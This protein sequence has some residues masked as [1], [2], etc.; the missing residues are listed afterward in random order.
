MDAA[1][2]I[3]SGLLAISLAA[4]SAAGSAGSP[5]KTKPQV[6]LLVLDELPIASLMKPDGNIDA[7]LFPNFARLQSDAT[8]FRNATSPGTFTHDVIPSILTGSRPSERLQEASFLPNNLFTLLSPTHRIYT[9]QPFPR[10]CPATM[11]RDMPRASK[12]DPL[13]RL[14]PAFSAGARGEKFMSLM[15]GIERS[16]E[17]RLLFAHFILPHQPWAYLPDGRRYLSAETLPGQY[18]SDGRGKGWADEWWLTAEAYQ[19]HLLQLRFTDILLGELIARLER[20]GIYDKTLL[21]LVAD[22]G[23][24]FERGAPKRMPQPQT[25]GEL[26]AVPFFVKKPFQKHGRVSDAPVEIVDVAPTIADVLGLPKEWPG[27]EGRSVFD[28]RAK[29]RPRWV[30]GFPLR[31]DG[32]EKYT[33]VA[34][35]Y[36]IFGRRRG[37]LDLF[38]LGPRWAQ[39]LIGQSATQLAASE[40]LSVDLANERSLAAASATSKILPSFLTGSILGAVEEDSVLAITIDGRIAAVAP[41]HVENGVTRFYCMLPPRLMSEAPN[42]IEVFRL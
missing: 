11:C 6:L 24:A 9:T 38:R 39:D 8:W 14:F 26:A 31:T 10:L 27:L 35:K 42:K 3:C 30:S 21:I 36:S 15:S 16:T 18:D 41:A 33:A 23:I 40:P 2:R 25:V 1:I 12:D 29:D 7:T 17:P 5:N 37:S 28:H 22:H 34:R 13:R 19:R 20:E 32:A 4:C